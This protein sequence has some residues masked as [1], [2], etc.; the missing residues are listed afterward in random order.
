MPAISM[1]TPTVDDPA[2]GMPHAWVLSA[3]V[4]TAAS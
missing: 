1:A 3:V 4:D 2:E